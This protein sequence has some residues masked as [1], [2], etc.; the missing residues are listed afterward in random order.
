MMCV[1]CSC[2]APACLSC[3]LLIPCFW[4]TRFPL[5]DIMFRE[6]FLQNKD[7]TPSFGINQKFSQKFDAHGYFESPLDLDDSKQVEQSLTHG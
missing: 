5:E 7:N 2:I 1:S 3:S 4:K 6:D